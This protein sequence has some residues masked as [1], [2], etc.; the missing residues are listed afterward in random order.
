MSLNDIPTRP[1]RLARRPPVIGVDARAANSERRAGIGT[2]CCELLRAIGPLCRE[3]TLRVYLD[4]APLAGFPLDADYADFRI[5]P[6][7]W[8]WTQRALRSE[9]R[10]D[11][12]D[13]FL[14]PTMQ[15]PFG[16][17][18]P[19]A[20][21]VHDLAFFDFGQYFTWR[22]R[23]R[24]VVQARHAV[25][26]A[27][28]IFAVSESAR[29]ELAR[30]LGIPHERV[31]VT[32]HGVSAAFT[33]IQD[34]TASFELRSTYRLPEKYILYVGRLQPRK[35]IERLIGAF[36]TLLMS[37]PDLPHDLVVAGDKG[38][39]CDQIFQKAQSSACSDRIHLLGFVS[40]DHLPSLMRGADVFALVSLWEG[41]GIPVIEAMA[42]GTAVVASNCS[43]LPEVAG[44]AAV[45][46]DPYSVESIAAGLAAVLTQDQFRA[47]LE[48][49]GRER[50]HKFSWQ[51]TAER[52][53]EV[54]LRLAEGSTTKSRR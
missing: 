14:A 41:F 53:L 10:R 33:S 5:L 38:W 28:H 34:E 50:A 30:K 27:D 21:T 36:E 31:T 3:G 35:N 12:P 25:R 44:D 1:L 51:T 45:L 4:H 48:A 40:A 26:R 11:P 52:T 32:P 18:C 15:V 23:L 22:T 46:V 20:V 8:A 24:S 9:L 13:V 42:C 47:D 29:D 37:H 54:L 16:V 39:L 6:S 7:T 49:R 19:I 43:S 2:Y 17:P